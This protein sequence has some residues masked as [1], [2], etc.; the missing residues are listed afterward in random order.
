MKDIKFFDPHL[1]DFVIGKD[2]QPVSERMKHT[3]LEFL[4][5]DAEFS[6]ATLDERTTAK[7]LQENHPNGDR[8]L[9]ASGKRFVFTD[10]VTIEGLKDTLPGK[11]NPVA[12]GSLLLKECS[13]KHEQL[14]VRVVSANSDPYEV[15]LANKNWQQFKDTGNLLVDVNPADYLAMGHERDGIPQL[16]LP[17][18]AM[19]DLDSKV[20]HS[21]TPT[22]IADKLDISVRDIELAP[23]NFVRS[24]RILVVDE[25]TG[26]S[27]SRLNPETGERELDFEH[28]DP[29]LA[30]SKVG[31]GKCAISCALAYSKF[32]VDERTIIQ[33]RMIAKNPDKGVS[34]S[35]STPSVGKGTV[36][37]DRLLDDLGFDMI[38]DNKNMFKGCGKL[39]PGIHTVEVWMGEIDRSKIGGKQ[40]VAA[41]IPIFPELLDDVIPVIEPAVANLSAIQNDPIAVARSFCDD[42]ERRQD[43]LIK[44]QTDLEEDDSAKPV[45]L[46]PTEK[47][48]VIKQ[49]VVTGNTSLLQ[50]PLCAPTLIDHLRTSYLSL[51]MGS[52]DDLKFNR[53]MIAPSNELKDGEV[54]ISSLPEGTELIIGRSP[55]I[56]G[57][58]VH[59]VKVKHLSNM[60]IDDTFMT[61]SSALMSEIEGQQGIIRD[62]GADFDGDSMFWG[63]KSKWTNLAKGVERHQADR[64]ADLNK[65]SKTEFAEDV[66]IEEAALHAESA[67]VGVIAN[68]LLKTHS[69]ISAINMLRNPDGVATDNDRSQFAQKIRDQLYNFTKWTA[70]AEESLLLRP[71]QIEGAEKEWFDRLE[72]CTNARVSAIIDAPRFD[73]LSKMPESDED[74]YAL[75]KGIKSSLYG[76]SKNHEDV[77]FIAPNSASLSAREQESSRDLSERSTAISKQIFKINKVW[78]DEPKDGVYDTEGSTRVLEAYQELQKAGTDLILQTEKELLRDMVGVASHQNQ[79]AVSM[80]KSATVT[81]AGLVQR[82]NHFLPTKTPMIKEKKNGI[83]YRDAKLTIDG[84]TPEEV[85]A[86]RVNDHFEKTQIKVSP[87]V[88]FKPLFDPTFSPEIAG[89][90]NEQKIAFDSDWNQAVRLSAKARS[91]EGAVLKIQDN[92]GRDIEVTNLCKFTHELAYSPDQ[93]QGLKFKI[94]FNW[95]ETEYGMKS[96][97]PTEHKYVLLAQTS[98]VAEP[99]GLW[100]GV[101]II[102]AY[103]VSPPRLQNVLGTVCEFSSRDHEFNGETVGQVQLFVSAKLSAPE[104]DLSAQHFEKARNTAIKFRTELI[105]EGADLNQYAAALW[106]KSVDKK[107]T[108]VDSSEYSAS[109]N[110]M[111]S[112]ICYFFPDQLKAQIAEKPLNLHRFSLMEGVSDLPIGESLHFKGERVGKYIGLSTDG[113]ESFDAIARPWDNAVPMDMS[114][115]SLSGKIVAAG[116]AQM[117][118]Q[119]PGIEE[120]I[121]F[122]AVDKNWMADRSWADG[123][124][125]ISFEPVSKVDH[126][127]SLNGKSI[128]KI[129]AVGVAILDRINLL[130]SD[131]LMATIVQ[132]AS[133]KNSGLSISIPKSENN[134]AVSF[135]LQGKGLLTLDGMGSSIDREVKLVSSTKHS[136][137]VFMTGD[138]GIKHQI[139]EFTTSNTATPVMAARTTHATSAK[140]IKALVKA[141][142][143]E[144]QDLKLVQHDG[145]EFLQ[146]E[147]P[148]RNFAPVVLKSPGE[149]QLM[150][151]NQN[152]A[153]ELD[154]DIEPQRLP[155]IQ[156]GFEES[157]IGR[158][159]G[160]IAPQIGEGV[161][162]IGVMKMPVVADTSHL[163]E[164]DKANAEISPPQDRELSDRIDRANA[165][166]AADSIANALP[167]QVEQ[168]ETLVRKSTAD[169]LA[170]MKAR[171]EAEL[172]TPVLPE[173]ESE[174]KAPDIR[175]G[176]AP[177]KVVISGSRSIETLPKEALERIDTIMGLGADI[178]V[179]DA[180]GVDTEVQKYLKS[181]DYDRVTVYHAY[182]AARNNEGFPAQRVEGTYTDRDKMMCSLADKGLAIWDGKSRGT[183]ANIDRVES[184]VVEVV[185]GLERT[186]SKA[187]NPVLD[188]Q[189]NKLTANHIFTPDDIFN[190]KAEALVDAVNC[191]GVKGAGLALQFKQNFPESFAEYRNYC[192]S[193]NMQPGSVL[194]SSEKDKLI[195]HFPTKQEW[196]DGSQIDWIKSGLDDLTT[197]V[198]DRGISSIAIPKLGCGLGGLDWA[199]VR[200]LIVAAAEKMPNCKVEIYGESNELARTNEKSQVAAQKRDIG[201]K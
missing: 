15:E 123:A 54:C 87:A 42:F 3:G 192:Q 120:P 35:F 185:P 135:D 113:G 152:F 11:V 12:Y 143:V 177:M 137:G 190:S 198:N 121:V 27:S 110:S 23:H 28:I 44:G 46:L 41:L 124:A 7:E 173:R 162:T 72:N 138:D 100:D 145:A 191:V 146:G 102:D 115:R 134:P 93:L 48:D 68:T 167:L 56:D 158:V 109:S 184:R 63:L 88:C 71:E 106:H 61:I 104:P 122:G 85:I 24:M 45:H 29:K 67:P 77:W 69:Q 194:I 182:S 55:T 97:I 171:T 75:A 108:D 169:L 183:K 6:I 90:V 47:Y 116:N 10:S 9:L 14:R 59:I 161:T 119:V 179:G 96:Y 18:S 8:M 195:V 153:L 16:L 19:P 166:W 34:G 112:A 39:E 70:K 2:K 149:A 111:S 133:G 164:P 118:L 103:D 136:L 200:P 22:E 199:E 148:N 156:Q 181:K 89:R 20:L 26:A 130:E 51:A 155:V 107:G 50:S 57:N 140:S 58:S 170:R 65:L 151:S 82:L 25:K 31:D 62:T 188:S 157:F 174:R 163:G 78:V 126:S 30:L 150:N 127:L 131:R 175:V 94:D 193:G 53:S 144:W 80:Q 168:V 36:L 147:K 172:T 37:A 99:H 33:M 196:K 17:K 128:G 186:Q 201:G 91:E 165:Q 154:P 81:E 49:A 76:F 83:V 132:N 52:H 142:Y 4:F 139:G 74:R 84:I 125:N 5:P 73:L 66:S 13:A 101:E 40:S 79:I 64:D 86:D 1:S 21:F 187:A 95:E 159:Y 197:Q 105:D 114:G 180:P 43:R 160:S 60:N 92:L 189:N 32:G 98:V 176:S 117:L 178:L 141:G 129:D 38:L